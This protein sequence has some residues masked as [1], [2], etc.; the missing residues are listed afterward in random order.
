MLERTG[1]KLWNEIP[2][3]SEHYQNSL[4]LNILESEDLYEDLES[5]ISKVR[6][7]GSFCRYRKALYFWS[8]GTSLYLELFCF[9][10]F[11]SFVLRHLT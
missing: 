11:I 3:S 2:I 10:S 6:K 4:L 9:L 5:I 8:L 1:A 7:Y